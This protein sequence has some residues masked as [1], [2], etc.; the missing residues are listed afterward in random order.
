MT[1]IG[2]ATLRV[3]VP[4]DAVA[5]AAQPA[6]CRREAHPPYVVLDAWEAMMVRR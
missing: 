4:A 1:G 5:G 3:V 2:Q 6:A